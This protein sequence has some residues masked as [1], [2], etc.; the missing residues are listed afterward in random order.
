MI[1]LNHKKLNVYTHSVEMV[2]E[3]YRLTEHFPKSETF[4]LVSQMR[5]AAV[6]VISNISE[7]ASRKSEK[8][9]IRFYEI[10][11]SS[12]VELDSQV[13]VSIKL[14]YLEPTSIQPLSN[15]A[16]QVFALLSSM[17]KN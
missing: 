5:R 17:I 6:S 9:R 13:E 2:S 1:E 7:G 15:L 14:G 8:E 12:L 3:V 11:R 4:G 10:A 16:N